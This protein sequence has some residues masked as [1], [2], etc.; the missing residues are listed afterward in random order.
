MFSAIKDIVKSTSDMADEAY[1]T[2]SKVVRKKASSIS[3]MAMQGTANFA[4]L[5]PDDLDL[6]D[7][8]MISQALEQRFS[9]FLLTIFTMNPYMVVDEKSLASGSI[10][11]DY[12]KKFHQNM[13]TQFELNPE[14]TNKIFESG[15][16]DESLIHDSMVSFVEEASEIIG[17]DYDCW[18]TEAAN[19][20]Y[21]LYEGVNNSGIDAL[22]AKYNYTIESV[23]EQSILNNMGVSTGVSSVLEAPSGVYKSTGVRDPRQLKYIDSDLKKSNDSVPTLLHVRVYPYVSGKDSATTLEPVDFVIGVKATLHQVSTSDMIENLSSGLR[24]NNKFFNFVRWTTGE[25]KFFKDFLFMV[26]QQK[27]DAK[28]STSSTSGWWSALRRRKASSTIRRFSKGKTI[29]PNATIVCTTDDLVVLRDTYGFNLLDGDTS[30]VHE[31]M[32]R[33]FL[34]SFVVVNPALQRVD[35]L[36]DGAGQYETSTY[37]TLSKTAGKDDKKFKE[38]MKMLGRGGM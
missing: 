7:A 2:A 12:L 31:L 22:N 28:Q 27:V 35:F 9:T 30:L 6:D 36:F 32:K 11:A 10:A 20:V 37:S 13:G 26:D 29:M 17:V 14:L 8:I 34:L 4:V 18:I 23:T 5:V 21:A 25:T 3:S 1:S 19:M 24:N 16:V 15:Q 33:Y 38:M